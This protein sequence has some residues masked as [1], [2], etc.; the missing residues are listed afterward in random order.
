MLCTERK[1]ALP[2]RMVH[3]DRYLFVGD[4]KSHSILVYSLERNWEFVRAM[5]SEGGG[6]GQFDVPQGMC[7]YRDRL[8]V[9]DCDNNRLQ[10]ID[11]SAADADNWKF[12]EPFGSS[13]GANG[14]IAAPTDAWRPVMCCSSR[15]PVLT[16]CRHSRS[17]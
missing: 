2:W 16:E 4:V 15:R 6:A 8:I 1:D 12:D 7:V 17:L 13:G 14:Q 11:I 3:T 5:G 10:F 9:C